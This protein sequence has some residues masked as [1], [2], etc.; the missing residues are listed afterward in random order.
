MAR[1]KLLV[2]ILSL[3][4]FAGRTEPLLAD[5]PT[6]GGF[7]LS[8]SMSFV[9]GMIP[10]G[11]DV[12]VVFT[13]NS[14]IV[15]FTDPSGVGSSLGF[16]SDYFYQNFNGSGYNLL[17]PVF[18]YSSQD[19]ESVTAPGG[20]ISGYMVFNSGQGPGGSGQINFDDIIA[21][22]DN[23]PDSIPH[24]AGANVACPFCS[25][26]NDN[27]HSPYTYGH[28]THATLEASSSPCVVDQQSDPCTTYISWQLGDQ[29][30]AYTEVMV[31]DLATPGTW[32]VFSPMQPLTQYCHEKLCKT[33]QPFSVYLGH[34]YQFKLLN[35]DGNTIASTSVE[36]GVNGLLWAQPS[37]CSL[38]GNSMCSTVINEK[39]VPPVTEAQVWVN[40]PDW[41]GTTWYLFADWPGGS[42]QSATAPWISSGGCTFNLYDTT[43]G[44]SQL[45][46]TFTVKGQ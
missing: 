23:F 26:L 9:A 42:S 11:S 24:G 20:A 12:Y 40:C 14:I 1:L 16:S 2:V 6:D 41:W 19:F 3:A 7:T 25:F 5:D 17:G 4:L 37:P 39:S 44:V 46:S 10:P 28:T 33:Q 13:G 34:Q 18:N 15:N 27:A 29:I 31:E 36:F 30:G 32:Y 22:G 43:P 21:D 35:L 45:L 8:D 38:E